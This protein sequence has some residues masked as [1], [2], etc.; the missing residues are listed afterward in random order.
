MQKKELYKIFEGI[1]DIEKN[2]I[3]DDMLFDAFAYDSFAKINLIIT[4]ESIIQG[5]LD[6]DK[7]LLCTSFGELVRLINEYKE[8][9]Y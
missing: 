3:D 6:I 7:V 8:I 4:I 1:L 9:I 2:T 5:R